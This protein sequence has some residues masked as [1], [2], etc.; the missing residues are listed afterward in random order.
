MTSY[1]D[2]D[3]ESTQSRHGLIGIDINGMGPRQR[4]GEAP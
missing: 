3:A 1:A 4:S 2:R